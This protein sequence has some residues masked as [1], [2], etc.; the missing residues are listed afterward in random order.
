MVISDTQLKKFQELYKQ[1]FGIEISSEEA[2]EKGIKLVC[3]LR[4]IYKPMTEDAF[5]AIQKR[6]QSSSALQD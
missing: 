5:N 6:R 3:L 4:C 2:Y 1:K